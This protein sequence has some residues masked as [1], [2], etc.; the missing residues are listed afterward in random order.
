MFSEVLPKFQDFLVSHNMT[1]KKTSSYYAYWVSSFLQFTNEHENLKVDLQIK[2][3]LDFL[4]NDKK[5]ADWKI[6]QARKAVQL[7]LNGFL[8][9]HSAN[10]GEANK[11]TANTKNQFNQMDIL[12][13][14]REFMRIKHYSYKTERSY[15]D[16]VKRFYDYVINQKGTDVSLYKFGCENVRSFLSY[17]AINK[18]VASS[19]QNQAFNALLLLF[20]EILK[21]DLKDLG[22]TVRAKRGPKL[23]VVLTVEEIQKI[24]TCVKEQKLL[25]IQFL[26]GSGLRLMELVRLRI[27]DVD[28][29]EGLV[30]VRSSKGDKDRVTMLPDVIK[31]DLKLHIE[32]VKNLHQKDIEDGYGEVYLP[33]ALFRK[34][35]NTAKK[36]G[37]QYIFP[38]TKLSVDPRSGKVRRH[39]INEKSIQ[40][41]VKEAIRKAEIVKNASVHTLRHSFATHLLMNGVNIREIQE[42][43]GHKNVETTMIYTHVLRNMSNIPKSPLDNLYEKKK[44]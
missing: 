30:F 3:F 15:L 37:W 43:L 18:R 33:D 38:S 34:Y 29:E 17:L 14:I 28:F 31:N 7:Y 44:T 32:R 24:F 23:P 13:K 19:T 35:P 20:R 27:K 39:H 6:Q 22:Q 12:N 21:I 4:E 11:Y 26:Y 9:E 36:W 25:F 10:L 5:I 16:W 42:L 40:N 8:Q 1:S 41:T 2:A